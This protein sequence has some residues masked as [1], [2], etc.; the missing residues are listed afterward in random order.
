MP[1]KIYLKGG[2]N[3]VVKGETRKE[4]IK[5]NFLRTKARAVALV[6]HKIELKTKSILLM[7]FQP[8]AEYQKQIKEKEKK[9]AEQAT[10]SL[11]RRCGTKSPAKYDHCPRCGSQLVK[12][13][14]P[15]LTIP[16][17]NKN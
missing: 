1:T 9:A 6:D 3:V 17:Q 15:M 16:G 12:K 11:C 14:P 10:A 13:Q 7:E 2:A 5:L 4:A 8:E